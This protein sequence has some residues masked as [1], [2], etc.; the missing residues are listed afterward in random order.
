MKKTVIVGLSI[1]TILFLI[2]YIFIFPKFIIVSGYAAKNMCSCLFVAGMDEETVKSEDFNFDML[3]LASVDI[4][5]D[6]KSV[7]ATVFGLNA[8]TAYYKENTGCT[9]INKIKSEDIYEYRREWVI[10]IYYS[11]VNWFNYIDTVE[12]LSRIRLI[13]LNTILKSAFEEED[14]TVHK[15]NTRA[16]L[17]LHKGQLVTEQY[18]PGFDKNSRL[19]GWSMTKSLTAS[20]LSMMANEERLNLTLTTGIALGKMMNVIR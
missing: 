14:S 2:F 16:A 17:V 5:Y 3:K 18:A 1:F 15:K 9:L 11:V 10:R 4:D 8:K 6:I 12:Y 7:T 19:M 13:K 20:M